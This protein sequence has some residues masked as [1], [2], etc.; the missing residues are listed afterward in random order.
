MKF[1]SDHYIAE[2]NRVEINRRKVL[3]GSVSLA[4]AGN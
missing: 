2:R 4:V 3:L 1:E